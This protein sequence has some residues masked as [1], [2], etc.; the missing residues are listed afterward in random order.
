MAPL[1]SLMLIF[2]AGAALTLVLA[3]RFEAGLLFLV[4]GNQCD[5]RRRAFIKQQEE[6]NDHL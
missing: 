6:E 2:Y 3:G 5:A 1:H 4:L